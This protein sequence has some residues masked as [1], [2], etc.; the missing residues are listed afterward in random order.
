MS[1]F[2]SSVPA[3]APAPASA[4]AAAAAAAVESGDCMLSYVRV[5]TRASVDAPLARQLQGAL[6]Q[7]WN[8]KIPI[9]TT[10]SIT[11][12]H[13]KEQKQ[14]E[15]FH[16]MFEWSDESVVASAVAQGK[17]Y[18]KLQPY[19]SF[20]SQTSPFFSPWEDIAHCLKYLLLHRIGST[21]SGSSIS[22]CSHDTALFIATADNFNAIDLEKLRIDKTYYLLRCHHDKR[23]KQLIFGYHENT[24]ATATTATATSSTATS[25]TATSTSTTTGTTPATAKVSEFHQLHTVSLSD[26]NWRL[27]VCVLMKNIASIVNTLKDFSVPLTCNDKLS[28]VDNIAVQKIYKSDNC[29]N[30]LDEVASATVTNMIC[31][32]MAIHDIPHTDKLVSVVVEVVEAGVSTMEK[33]DLTKLLP[34]T[35]TTTAA[36]GAVG[37]AAGAVGAALGGGG[38]GK[39]FICRFAPI[40]RSY[41]P[42]VCYYIITVLLLLCYVIIAIV[43]LLC[44]YCYGIIAMVLL[45]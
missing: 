31:M 41:L 40:G 2:S 27:S 23:S 4:A 12:F 45:L 20:S 15:L 42:E 33:L 1:S 19:F 7:P 13:W 16:T 25:S 24:T 30:T 28:I 10:D 8:V 6:V 38:G 21:Q 29:G 11:T 36:A 3:S 43:L 34:A 37:A 35:A 39:S 17:V 44:Y 14:T 9:D 26:D 5:L 22:L 32:Y 18:A